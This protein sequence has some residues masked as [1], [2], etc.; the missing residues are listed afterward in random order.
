[1]AP[2]GGQDAAGAQQ[3]L[4]SAGLGTGTVAAMLAAEATR[5]VPG[6]GWG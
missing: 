5:Q 6:H 2:P 4:T 3:A 1:M